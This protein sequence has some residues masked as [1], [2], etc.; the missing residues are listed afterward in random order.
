[1]SNLDCNIFQASFVQK[2]PEIDKWN[3]QLGWL[4]SLIPAF[5]NKTSGVWQP[6]VISRNN[7]NS[8]EYGK[9]LSNPYNTED[10]RMVPCNCSTGTAVVAR[11]VQ[12]KIA[13]FGTYL[14]NEPEDGIFCNYCESIRVEDPKYNNCIVYVDYIPREPG[15]ARKR[16]TWPIDE[17]AAESDGDPT[18]FQP[19]CC[20][21]GCDTRA[22]TDDLTPKIP[23]LYTNYHYNFR[24][25]KHHKQFPAIINPG[26]GYEKFGTYDGKYDD[27]AVN[28]MNLHIDWVLEPRIGEIEP[29][30]NHANTHHDNMY[31]HK[32]SYKNYLMQ[33]KT[34]GNFILTKVNT[35][36]PGSISELQ[37]QKMPKINGIH[38]GSGVSTHPSMS[39]TKLIPAVDKFTIPYGIRDSTHW[40]I[41]LK[42]P[43]DKEGGLWKWNIS[44]GII[45]WYRYYDKDRTNDTRPIP[46]IDLYISDGD[47]FFATNDGPEPL[48]MPGSDSNCSP[49]SC[50]SG[51]KLT[52]YTNL[53]AS[54][55]TV[56]PSGS[57]FIYISQNLYAQTYKY[58]NKIMDIYK[59]R[60]SSLIY[61]DI[62]YSAA[63][64]ST[65]PV[66]D[67]IT[68]DLYTTGNY[69]QE[70][71]Q[72]F[73]NLINTRPENTGTITLQQVNSYYSSDQP[74]DI[75][76]RNADL[77]MKLT[78]KSMPSYNDLNIIQT[79]GDLVNTLIH[80]YGGYLWLN[81]DSIGSVSVNKKVYPNLAIDINFEPVIKHSDTFNAAAPR[82]RLDCSSTIRG[83][84]KV[85]SYDQKFN[86]SNAT[87]SSRILDQ[88][89]V[90]NA[91]CDTGTGRP[92]ST[93][94]DVANTMSVFANDQRIHT[95][96]MWESQTRFED[97]Y[98]RFPSVSSTLDPTFQNLQFAQDSWD[99][100]NVYFLAP[101]RQY[102][103]KRTY[104]A[105]IG[106]PAID[107]V[108]FHRDGGFYYDSSALNKYPGTGTVAFIK[109]FR[110]N[111]RKTSPFVE[112]KTYD[113]GL[114]FYDIDIYK[115][116]DPDNLSC[117]TMPL[118]QSC[119]CW[120]LDI[121]QSYPYKCNNNGPV[122]LETPDLYTPYLSTA[123][124]PIK[125]YGGFPAE[126]V[127]D[128]LG[129]FRFPNHP[130]IGSNLNFTN[131]VLDPVNNFGCKYT[132]GI[133]LYTLTNTT[134][135]VRLPDWDLDDADV[136]VYASDG[137]IFSNR[138]ATLLIINGIEV[139]PNTQVNLGKISRDLTI[140][141]R[142][143]FLDAIFRD[144]HPSLYSPNI[145]PCSRERGSVSSVLGQV[146][147]TTVIFGRV[148]SQ[149]KV[150]FSLPSIS[151]M[152]SISAARFDPNS[153]I[154]GG[155]QGSTLELKNNGMFTFGYDDRTFN[156]S[157]DY[158][159]SHKTYSGVISLNEAFRLQ[160]LLELLDNTKKLR[161]YVKLNNSWYEY[162]DHRTFGYYNKNIDEQYI[163]WPSIFSENHLT[164][165]EQSI[166][167]FIPAIP[168]VPLEMVYV[169][170][171]LGA[172]SA[173][174]PKDYYPYLSF[175][176]FRNTQD[177]K[178]IYIPGSRAYFALLDNDSKD[179]INN[180]DFIDYTHESYSSYI[181]HSLKVSIPIEIKQDNN[182]PLQP[183]NIIEKSIV[184][185]PKL[186]VSGQ[187]NLPLINNVYNNIYTKLKLSTDL[188][189]SVINGSFSVTGVNSDQQLYSLTS[190]APVPVINAQ[191]TNII[192]LFGNT[193]S[194]DIGAL[195][196]FSSLWS[197]KYYLSNMDILNSPFISNAINQAYAPYMYDNLLSHLIANN[198]VKSQYRISNS[199]TSIP[200]G[201]MM[202][203]VQ[204]QGNNNPPAAATKII[205][206]TG[207]GL[208][209][210]IHRPFSLNDN[211]NFDHIA[212]V[213]DKYDGSASKYNLYKNQNGLIDI[214]LVSPLVSNEGEEEEPDTFIDALT[215]YNRI[216]NIR[217]P[218]G[219]LQISGL[220]K[221][222]YFTPPT[223]AVFDKVPFFLDLNPKFFLKPV[224]VPADD[225]VSIYSNSFAINDPYDVYA[226]IRIESSIDPNADI[227]ECTNI[228]TPNIGVPPV[229]DG[230]GPF[231]WSK[232]SRAITYGNPYTTYDIICDIDKGEPCYKPPL[233]SAGLKTTSIGKFNIIS[234]YYNYSYKYKNIS[235]LPNENI[236]IAFGIDAGM[237][238]SIG[239]NKSIPQVVRAKFETYTP[240]FP[241]INL[242]GNTSCIAGQSFV[243]LER[244]LRSW[245]GT[246]QSEIS[247]H[248]I[249][250][251]T[252]D[253]WA[254]EL[255]FRTLYG[256]KEDVGFNDI[257][258]K[259]SQNIISRTSI[260]DNL[261]NNADS[262]LQ[263]LYDSIPMDYDTAS[264][265][266][267]ITINGAISI[268]GKGAVGD[269]IQFYYNDELFI[270]R[271]TEDDQAVYAECRELGAKGMLFEK[272]SR[273]ISYFLREAGSN[274]SSIIGEGTS[275]NVVGT[276]RSAGS[277]SVGVQCA[278]GGENSFV[279][280]LSPACFPAPCY[281]NCVDGANDFYPSSIAGGLPSFST[282]PCTAF[283][284]KD[285]NSNEHSGPVDNGWT[286]YG[287][288]N[289]FNNPVGG[290]SVGLECGSWD[291]SFGR[292][293][294]CCGDA[295]TGRAVISYSIT[296]C[297]Y[298]FTMIGRVLNGIIGGATLNFT[299]PGPITN[300][301]KPATTAIFPYEGWS[302]MF[303][304]CNNPEPCY[305]FADLGFVDCEKAA[306]RCALNANPPTTQEEL[307]GCLFA[308]YNTCCAEHCGG[309]T[310][311]VRICTCIWAEESEPM[312]EQ[313]ITISNSTP[314]ITYEVVE[315]TTTGPSDSGY[316]ADCNKM[317]AT[318]V[319]DNEILRIN[320]GA[321]IVR[322]NVILT[323]GGNCGARPISSC[324]KIKIVLPDD[325]YGAYQNTESSCEKCSKK[326]NII[327]ITESPS[328]E[329]TTETKYCILGIFS[330]VTPV[331]NDITSGFPCSTKI[332]QQ[333]P[334]LNSRIRSCGK[335]LDSYKL[336][337][338]AYSAWAYF[339]PSAAVARSSLEVPEG[340][341]C[342]VNPAL[343]NAK[344]VGVDPVMS[345][346]ES[347]SAAIEAWKS[348]MAEAFATKH[349][350]F[351]TANF[352]E[353]D[354]IEG[355]IPGS[356]SLNFAG[357][358]WPAYAVRTS[359]SL[360]MEQGTAYWKHD[361][362]VKQTSANFQVAY[363][364]YSYK[365]PVSVQD[366]FVEIYSPEITVGECNSFF[367]ATPKNALCA[368]T[369]YNI[370]E[371]F[372]ST[373]TIDSNCPTD[374]QCYDSTR[375]CAPR[376][377]CCGT[378]YAR[379]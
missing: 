79:T 252:I 310:F 220:H 262:S 321:K 212:R 344:L 17:E 360:V 271:I 232:F 215:L 311:P 114:K 38:L 357:G 363:I 123:S 63:I 268:Y 314:G 228:I 80:K 57:E 318:I 28:N 21:G 176:F 277:T 231:D 375:G 161:L 219:I 224:P 48:A 180:E 126:K 39:I 292:G 142:N 7:S 327:E 313:Y 47:V 178:T 253:T 124:N 155:E 78:N 270:I 158:N 84:T 273:S 269:N 294:S 320:V 205:S 300:C 51:L 141:A 59:K 96:A 276:C 136:W 174:I 192:S 144:N 280:Q 263:Y 41:F 54:G 239:S 163:G 246:F 132:A 334:F 245:D 358:S 378:P 115:L 297:H 307:Y 89:L 98:S 346:G 200:S 90:Y 170:N 204:A 287:I 154:I 88:G 10:Q 331:E 23:Y 133:T 107:L 243:P 370:K 309:S 128:L 283:P 164:N 187:I 340:S 194:I 134:W 45:G 143:I 254:N 312:S 208:S 152:T 171:D 138:N 71:R 8:V 304:D 182:S 20:K 222:T 173:S 106:H 185:N 305:N 267:N 166:G 275:E 317:I 169:F 76:G 46:Q 290:E 65:G 323:N 242:L 110:I 1:M 291:A 315:T 341:A 282:E 230:G 189:G 234:K 240:L 251:L 85:F 264:T 226:G 225:N 233:G 279:Q 293:T 119:K 130:G 109:N 337:S 95:Q 235:E 196:K 93:I 100:A 286:R 364:S 213:N 86:I 289:G 149:S 256:S 350:C 108:A 37:S 362:E 146:R 247:S 288:S 121:V 87:I 150:V 374:P 129:D 120:D 35:S 91:L 31:S 113:V 177:K 352:N 32:K 127:Q 24:D 181:A 201:T 272:F 332:S 353:D 188:P 3:L 191:D 153:G 29:P 274:A 112:F 298:T 118:D 22:L 330:W 102:R 15:I 12:Q 72:E 354:L 329:T 377:Y 19:S 338:T 301:D 6:I 60:S 13:L 367:G 259:S 241:D 184:V 69:S 50:P 349:F 68:V 147:S 92:V 70:A 56:V 94:T 195:S 42:E 53:S 14:G 365:R 140:V 227:S 244:N 74:R 368:S 73:V 359:R 172:Q 30:Q 266:E 83:T 193:G 369:A 75:Y 229:L 379:G 55:M 265:A 26:L 376:N 2:A 326:R 336:I 302:P 104:N 160:T 25:F 210:Y 223:G 167:P 157:V 249:D 371:I 296:N 156:G 97:I 258:K 308:G 36:D 366:K 303:C 49:K 372:K 52:N 343:S 81:K 186:F 105:I 82:N 116:R 237:Y 165:V 285:K 218:F 322:N 64:L 151:K 4:K 216:S 125:A 33:N 61:K 348:N 221:P 339:L 207:T 324:P 44:S 43:F 199:G 306:E 103:H 179:T 168:K 148:P 18:I 278:C 250:N 345:N 99:D 183:N 117:S 295:D 351:N 27:I 122:V 11:N 16:L 236:E 198:L 162:Q 356:C 281:V 255:I 34:C 135:K 190:F 214:N 67:D 203:R 139:H 5:N 9:L 211:F 261:I 209:Y 238:T 40:N 202:W 347:A 248:L 137:D 101:D 111:N 373:E 175:A 58:M 316:T 206:T 145:F 342:E 284:I 319:Y 361:S 159:T 66:F 355:P 77:V 328:F 333:Y 335:T 217:Y 131:K 197:D 257:S 260:L 62:L 325:T 299:N